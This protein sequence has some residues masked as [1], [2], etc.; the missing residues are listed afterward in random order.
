MTIEDEVLI[1]L[2]AWRE[3]RGGGTQGMQSVINVIINRAN[4]RKT[5]P[6]SECVRA[7]QFSSITAKG[8][9]ELTLWPAETDS[10]WIMAKSM[11][12]AAANERLD[13]LTGGATLYYAPLDISNKRTIILGEIGTVPFPEDW[14]QG[15]VKFTVEIANQ[16]FFREV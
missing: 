15:A 9:P 1:A 2:T 12:E 5:T 14:N 11:A 8:D 7:L 10:E 6:Y 4:H 3:N 13:D 16:L